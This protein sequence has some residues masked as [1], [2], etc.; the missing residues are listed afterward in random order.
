MILTDVNSCWRYEPLNPLFHK[1]FDY[2]RSFKAEDFAPGKVVLQ[3]KELYVNLN[4]MDGKTPETSKMEGHLRYIDV[5]FLIEGTER[6]GCVDITDAKNPISA[7][8]EVKDRKFYSDPSTYF[9]DLRPGQM[10][11]V[12]PEDLH[13]PNISEGHI[14]KMTAKVLM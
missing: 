1:L 2:F 3:G 11:I 8:D 5:H 6:V 13:Q 14:K 7:Y 4:E 12:F 9:V 10:V